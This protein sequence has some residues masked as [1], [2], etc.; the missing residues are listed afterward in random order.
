[1]KHD[2][3]GRL[4][5]VI[6]QICGLL[7]VSFG[8]VALL[9]WF[10]ELPLL[11][12][13]GTNLI[14]MAPS[15]ASL[16]ALL[17][18][19]IFLCTRWPESHFLRFMG[20]GISILGVVASLFLLILSSQGIYLEA[21]HLGLPITGSLDGVPVGHMSPVTAS[22][23]VL[24][25]VSFSLS[26][27]PTS[28]QLP[29]LAALVTAFSA[30]LASYV[31]ILVY[32]FG[33]PL[34]YGGSIIPP[35]L[36][37]SLAFLALGTGLLARAWA[38][39]RPPEEAAGALSA[40][41]PY[42]LLLIFII[43]ALSIATIGYIY[44]NNYE[45]RY[46]TEVEHQLSAIA[47]LKVSGLENWRAERLGDA[48][49][50]YHDPASAMLAQRFFENPDDTQ[51][52]SEIRAW[53]ES[54]LTYGQYD[55]GRLL[56]TEGV[57]R[58][59]VPAGLPPV[60]SAVIEAIPNVVQTGQVTLVDFYRNQQD[61]RIYMSVLI[62]VG[63]TSNGVIGIIALRIDPETYLYPYLHQWYTPSETAETMLVRR[64]GEDVLILNPL[65]F[66][67]DT[68]LEMSIPLAN[69]DVLAVKAVLGETGIVEGLG[70]QGEPAI[71]DMRPV[72]DSPWYL[73]AH[74][75][76]DEIYTPLR[77]RMGQT[78]TF[79]G[80]L[81]VAS[82]AGLA[83]AWRQQR[84]RYYRERYETT[85]ALRESEERYRIL[86]DFTSDWVYWRDQDGRFIYVSPSCEKITGYSPE[87]FRKDPGLLSRIVH[88][89]DRDL[90]ES[91]HRNAVGAA[92]V[93]GPDFRIITRAGEIRCLN[94]LC[95][96]VYD[97]AGKY[98]G[99]R[100]ANRDI[101][102]R[103]QTEQA[104]RQS[105]KKFRDLVENAMVGVYMTNV[106]GDVLY[107]NDTALKIFGFD[108][109]DELISSGAVVRYKNPK[110]RTVLIENL[111]QK[112]SIRDFEFK[113]LTKTGTTRDI[114]LSAVLTSDVLMGMVIDITVR[115][116]AEQALQEYS[117][118]LETDVAERTRQLREAQEQLVRQERLATLGQLAGS[119]GH[120]LRNPLGVITNAVYFLKM[121]QPDANATVQE[122]LE[123]I[124]N[125]TRTSDKIV[126]DLLDFTRIKSVDPEPA[127]V[128]ELVQQT[129]QRFPAP[130][131]MT[132]SLKFPKRLPQVYADPHHVVQ[133]LGNLVVNAYQAMGDGGKLTV[134]ATVQS[135]MIKIAVKDTGEGISPENMNKLF[136]PLFTT[137]T[138]GIG[139]GLAVS[140]K[141]VEANGGRI[142]VQ[143][144]PG[145][146]STF[147]VYLP[148]YKEAN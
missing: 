54:Y 103:K 32:F 144:E 75:D 107:V 79:F 140:R 112:G 50:I 67:P 97:E 21:E 122:Y 16:F 66:Q 91:H 55:R 126:T 43:L 84:V 70:C 62:P 92:D 28:S 88:P 117:T 12:S 87:E 115:K 104:L 37:T 130:L 58:L 110:D 125:E 90:L 18:V 137:K 96:P 53:L 128:P 135:G 82:G 131:T 114:L 143:S 134:S 94:H 139:L 146:G 102:E 52:Q 7:A 133:I 5:D 35:S 27:L 145:K 111:K 120:E 13:F 14:P 60:S 25:S 15:T 10:L 108:S 45:Q 127:S 29:A 33:L 78:V 3:Q 81:I 147:T 42:T 123:I 41:V 26:L 74:V 93:I 6:T 124:E 85:E 68:A 101:T 76:T 100:A 8:C 19:T 51:V 80:A 73:I 57:A 44:Y 116:Q 22:L 121:A 98:R 63:G 138:R 65:R 118:R 24:V 34:L 64:D 95:R 47:E 99:R 38:Q 30:G 2:K 1:M 109:A 61:Q 56:D 129:L 142:E 86:A 11:S 83:L 141:L 106:K 59:S 46:R 89:E 136:E 20:M 72:P 40:R 148:V 105:E 132:V 17:G 39:V 71:G 69:T 77:E 113:A 23:F 119:I 31:L 9:G 48:N 36:P 4:L 49:V